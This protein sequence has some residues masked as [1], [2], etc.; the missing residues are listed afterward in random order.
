[1]KMRG[2]W[3]LDT[4][5][6]RQVTG[7]PT[8]L[9]GTGSYG[10][11]WYDLAVAVDPNNV[12]RIYLGGSTREAAGWTHEADKWAG[13]LYRCIVTSSG[14]GASLSYS[15]TNTAIGDTVHADIHALAFT[16]GNSNRLWVG[17]DGG[18]FFA[19]NATGGA[20][21]IARNTG[22]ST[23]TMEH[24]SQHPTEDAVLFCGMQDNGTG[25]FTGE[26]AWLHMAPGDG[27]FS[28]VNWHN[29]YRVVVTYP[30]TVVRRFTDG[31]S[32]YNYT[33]VSLLSSDDAI[34]YA[35]MVGTPR[36]PGSPAQAER[37]AI[38]TNRP[39]I[40]DSFGGGWDSIPN[41]NTSDCLGSGSGFRIKS[42][43]FASY[44]RLYIGT[45][46]G[47]VYRYDEG[48]T[49]WSRTRIDDDGGLP[50]DY[51]LPVTD[52]AVDLADATGDSI[53]VTFGGLAVDYRRVWHYDGTDWE[54][55][56]GPATNSSQQLLDVQ[57]NAI[58]VDPSHTSH[59]Y[60]GADIGIWRSTDSGATW[61][62]FSQGLPDA[63]VLDLLLHDGRRLLRAATH[64]RG[65]YERRLD[66][67]T[68]QGVELYVRDTQLDQGRF[69][70]VNW[71]DDPTALG[72]QVRHWRGP[73]IKLDTPDA[74]GSYQFPLTGDI[75]F[76][77]FVDKL[78][79]DSRNVATHATATI[80]TRVY[81]QVHNRGVTPADNVRVML[82]LAN[83]SAGLPALPANYHVNVQN[84]TPINTTNWQTVGIFSLDDVRVGAP[85]IAAFNLTSDM[86]PPP[87]SL[88]GND[89]HCVLA[90]L[91]HADDPYTSTVTHTDN[92]SRQER[93]AAHKNLK[94]VQFTGALPSAPAIMAIRINNALLEE[95]LLTRLLMHLQ[96]YPGP[97]RLF[98]PPMDIDGHLEEML[99]GLAIGQEFDK[100]KEWAE[101]HAEMIRENQCSDHPYNKLW[102][103]QR[104]HDIE[105]ALA[106]DIMLVAEDHRRVGIN[107]IVMEPNSYHTIFIMFDRPDAE[108]G[109][110]FEIEL[111][112]EDVERE[113]VI[114][115]LSTRVEVVP[116]P[117][118]PDK[119]QLRLWTHD[120]RRR[121]TV[122][123]A[124]LLGPDDR[125]VLP[126]EGARILFYE[127]T[128][129]G[130]K[131]L[132]WMRWH[133][134][135]RTFYAFL[136]GV[137]ERHFMAEGYMMDERV[138]MAKIES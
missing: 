47:R 78:S 73:D 33:Y 29:P 106:S 63:A 101:K 130:V 87:A 99:E 48:A 9:F 66:T 21:F 133:R 79:D 44:T 86:L 122:V 118:I 88:T 107:R 134:G 3:R 95:H 76:Y 52:I 5:T 60:V 35:P 39:W 82:L 49:G 137:N 2:V 8:D 55:R 28:V 15:M 91:H 12:N 65:V 84:G 93:K 94:V 4:N 110:T 20:S 115:G 96:G 102:V 7:H 80:T 104:M 92:N 30:S 43:A 14:S 59:L 132:G 70:T 119:Y 135:W 138:A 34:F 41:D 114:G 120:W 64:G 136:R 113:Q 13:S 58:V 51:S 36:N 1:M 125:P 77:E 57:H 103:E 117:R 37:L 46:N 50:S 16:P 127:E 89:H 6:W 71:R 121:Y 26:E 85:K 105:L 83:A 62:P 81:V 111:L 74:M 54:Q 124:T 61:V 17:C 25:R 97:V 72:E 40:S 109:D 10:Q 32:R 123:R 19:D 23:L 24:L 53:Y 98:I 112:Q 67:M 69:T 56:S 126:E 108:I 116:K 27:G 31:G 22:L 45:M 75:D 90:L 18:V 38:A 68:V 128:R 129:E 42:M 131:R 11:G 100:F